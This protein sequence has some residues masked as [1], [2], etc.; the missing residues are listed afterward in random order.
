MSDRNTVVVHT[1]QDL[2][3][4]QDALTELYVHPNQCY[5]VINQKTSAQLTIFHTLPGKRAQIATSLAPEE[6]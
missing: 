5:L 3:S 1:E 6:Y 4:L 2:C